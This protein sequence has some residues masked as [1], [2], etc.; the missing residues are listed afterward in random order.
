M[1]LPLDGCTVVAL[2][3]AVA[4]PLATRQLADLGARI[5]KIERPGVGDFAR[6]YDETVHGL[7]SYFV[8]LNRSKESVTLDIKAAEGAEILHQLLATADVFVQNLLPGATARLGLDADTLADRFPR[9]VVCDISG[10]GD[11]GPYRDKKAYDLLIQCEAAIVAVTGTESEPVKV[12]IAVADIAAGMYAF[13][14]ILAALLHR[15]RTGQT[16]PVQVSMLEAVGEWMGQPLLYTAYGGSPPPRRGAA[17]ASIAPY[18]PFRTAD[19]TVQLGVQNEREWRR[20]CTD[21]LAAPRLAADQRFATNSRRIARL[22][23]LTALIEATFRPLTSAEV[24]RRLDAASI[25]NAAVNDVAAFAAHPQLTARARWRAVGTPAGPVRVLAPPAVP[26]GQ[27]P[28]LDP[29]PAL[30]AHTKAVLSEL[31]WP[32]GK[33]AGLR[34]RGVI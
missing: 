27:E 29:V 31:G 25:A 13:S 9:L 16:R 10:Y 15:E 4:A 17:H 23:E 28:R 30:G 7:S 14:G 33:I 1:T 3:Q 2:E 32:A 22:A 12:G 24:I 34:E 26:G 21:V 5:V 20:F 18:G 6:G 11:T 19:G 8:W